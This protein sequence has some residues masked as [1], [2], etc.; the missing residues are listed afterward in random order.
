MPI[1]TIRNLSKSFGEHVILENIS[2]DIKAGDRIGLVGYNGSG[3][4]TLANLLYG[5]FQPDKGT[6][7]A[8]KKG[9]SI[10][11][12]QQSVDYSAFD[13]EKM[14]TGQEEGNVFELTSQLGLPEAHSWEEERF[15][16]LSGGERLK[17]ALANIWA[18]SPDILL[19]DEPT[20]HLDM[21]GTSWL[22]ERLKSFQGAVVIISHDRYFLDQTVTSILELSEKNI[23]GYEGNYSEYRIEKKKRLEVQKH[24]YEVQQ[25]YK[26]RIENQMEQLKDWSSK[27]HRESTKQGDTKLI[28]AKEYHRVKAKKRDIQVRS[29]MNRLKQELEKNK[30]EKPKEE[31]K[32]YFEFDQGGKR[33]KRIL[34]ATDIE[35]SYDER[36][37]FNK[38]SFYVKHGERIGLIGKNGTGKTTLIKAIMGE[39]ELTNGELWTSDSIKIAYLSQDVSD[40]SVEKTTLEILNISDREKIFKARTMFANMGM[41]ESLLEQP[42]STLS[43]GQRTR[44]K[45]VKM[46]LSDYDILILDEPTNHLDLPSREQLEDTLSE[47]TGTLLIVSHDIYFIEKL[48]GQLLVIENKKINRFEMGLK[49]YREKQQAKMKSSEQQSKEEQLLVIET[50]MTAILGELS[51]LTINDA[52]YQALDQE[53]KE[54][55]KQKRELLH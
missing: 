27:A 30:I 42:V 43:L 23:T 36:T 18:K 8:L 32:V 46:L 15:T 3:K 37:L 25:K 34:Q 7:K 31:A 45:L 13:L 55:I 41:K 21:D 9:L 19:L 11:Y 4:T 5:D 28:G 12:L 29:K 52:S 47:F 22:I 2:F 1:L 6:I 39:E 24:Q 33:G 48:C 16:H 20:N 14:L 38:S 44:V 17:V 50:I 49:E 40:L 51:L 53:Y 26:E 35:K 54:L 10:G